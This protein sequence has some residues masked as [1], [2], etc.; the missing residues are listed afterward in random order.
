MEENKKKIIKSIITI[1][2]LLFF[3]SVI[4]INFTAAPYVVDI[5]ISDSKRFED[6]VIFNVAVGNNLLKFDK[7]HLYKCP[8]FLIIDFYL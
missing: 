2:V 1:S 4:L 7:P 6:K 5:E 3:G 8:I